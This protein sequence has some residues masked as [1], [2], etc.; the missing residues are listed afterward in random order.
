MGIKEKIENAKPTDFLTKGLSKEEIKE[1]VD[2]VFD[3][4]K[5]V[6]THKE[7]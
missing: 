4:Q 2:S 5:E 3:K 7:N 6:D 1:I